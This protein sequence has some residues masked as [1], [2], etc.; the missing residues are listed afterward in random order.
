MY[1]TFAGCYVAHFLPETII[2][3]II[4][5]MLHVSEKLLA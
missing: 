1:E 3:N 2:K 4:R 5:E